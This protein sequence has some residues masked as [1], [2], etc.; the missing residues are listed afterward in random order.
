MTSNFS[1]ATYRGNKQSSSCLTIYYLLFTTTNSGGHADIVG[2]SVCL[3]LCRKRTL[4]PWPPPLCPRCLP[5]R[6]PRVS[7]NLLSNLPHPVLSILWGKVLRFGSI[8]STITVHIGNPM[9]SSS[10]KSTP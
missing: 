2:L 5:Y 10:P 6:F 9:I 4:C 3:L 7:R 1:N 8:L